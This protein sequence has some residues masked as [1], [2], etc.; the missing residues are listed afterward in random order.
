[1]SSIPL[2][3]AELDDDGF[4]AADFE[5]VDHMSDAHQRAILA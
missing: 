1:M 4:S 5:T 2:R 3:P